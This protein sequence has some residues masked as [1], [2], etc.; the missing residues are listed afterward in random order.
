MDCRDVNRHGFNLCV[1]PLLGNQVSVISDVQER[2]RKMRMRYA[3][4]R[5]KILIVGSVLFIIA[6]DL[7]EKELVR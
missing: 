6:T 2:F 4:S 3:E 1:V 5:E 7:A